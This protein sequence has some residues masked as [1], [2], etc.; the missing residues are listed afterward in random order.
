[1]KQLSFTLYLPHLSRSNIL[2]IFAVS[3]TFLLDSCTSDPLSPGVEFM[4]DMYRSPSYETYG[5]NAMYADSMSAR[6]PVEGTIPRGFTPYMNPDN[7]E[8][9]A[10]AD[11]MKMPIDINTPEN[12][13]EGKR[14]YG[15]FCTHCHGASGM[16][17][18][19]VA[20]KLPGPPPAY[21]GPQLK[22][23]SEGK[24]F[25]S[26][27]YGKNMMGSHA[28]QL[29]AEQRWKVITYVKTLQNPGGAVADT[30]AKK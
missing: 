9:Y 26:I 24:M 14:L 12:L 25:H 7:N 17:D 21:S 11:S 18:G 10:K 23:L 15:I 4:P 16:G 5:V 22:N 20:A 19:L 30:T 3:F 27:T 6:K 1:M 13:E 2:L 8:G 28:S 29:S